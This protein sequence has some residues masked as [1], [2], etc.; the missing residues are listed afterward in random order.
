MLIS[1]TRRGDG[2]VQEQVFSRRA[3]PVHDVQRNPGTRPP[4][5]S[6]EILGHPPTLD[7]AGQSFPSSALR[8][9]LWPPGGHLHPR[10]LLGWVRDLEIDFQ[11]RNESQFRYPLALKS[12]QVILGASASLPP[13]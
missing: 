5:P 7:V 3:Q 12:R 11:N 13:K 8:L 2:S 1:L 9:H 10:F 4:V 6:R